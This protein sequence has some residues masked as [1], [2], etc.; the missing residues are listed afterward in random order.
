[1]AICGGASLAMATTLHPGDFTCA[2]CGQKF[3]DQIVGSCSTGGSDSEFRPR[4]LG[5]SPIPYFIHT[6]PHCHFADDSHKANLSEAEKQ[7]IHK[8]LEEYC[9][10]HKCSQMKP[11]EK[12]EILA[13]TRELRGLPPLKVAEAYHKAAWM[14]DDEKNSVEAKRFRQQ[15][16]RRLAEALEGREV[17]EELRPNLTYL[18]G[19]LHRRTGDFTEALQWFGRV[20]APQ[21]WLAALVKQQRELAAQHNAEPA[22]MPPHD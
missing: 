13:Q 8:Y 9:R 11:S 19:E 4:Y 2:L 7:K 17:K 3:T 20:Q 5:M 16:S 21:P 12:Y 22:G 14:A 6:C 18:V 10:K 15:A 1:L